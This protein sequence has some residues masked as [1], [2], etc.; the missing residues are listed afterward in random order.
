LISGGLEGFFF[1][2]KASLWGIYWQNGKAMNDLL[3]E[4]VGYQHMGFS[5]LPIG[6]TVFVK[7]AMMTT[8][9]TI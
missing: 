1:P 6:T 3:G 5:G 4:R 2:F 9:S 8:S 7:K